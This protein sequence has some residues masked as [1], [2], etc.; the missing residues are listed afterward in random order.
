MSGHSKWSTIKRKKAK[1]DSQRGKIFT[2]LAKEIIA[3][4]RQGGGDPEA[5]LRLKNAIAKAKEVNIPNENIQRAIKRGTGE[6]SG[7]NYEELTYEGY[8]PGGV[9]VMLDIMTDNRNRTAGEIR[10]LFSKYG[11]NLGETG[12]VS[13]MFDT[14]G[15]L[16][17]EKANLKVD[18][19][20]FLLTALDAGALDVKEEDDSLEVITEPDALNQ[21]A[22]TLEVEGVVISHS[23]VT[24]IPQNTVVLTGSQQEQMLKLMEMLEDHDDVQEV[25]ANFDILDEE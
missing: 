21:V 24:R 5:N 25:Y 18:T 4:A 10:H 6:L 3:A 16:I 14:R 7:A 2:K 23:E 1:V 12:C 22:E 9:A 15:V 8:G 13:W 17:I 19:D 11:G 20:E